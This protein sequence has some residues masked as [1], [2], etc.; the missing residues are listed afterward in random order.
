MKK[1]FENTY[2]NESLWQN[3]EQAARSINS[4]MKEAWLSD[5][6]IEFISYVVG[7]HFEAGSIRKRLDGLVALQKEGEKTLI[8]KKQDAL[9]PKYKQSDIKKTNLYTLEAFAFYPDAIKQIIYEEMERHRKRIK[10]NTIIY[11]GIEPKKILYLIART[12][13][14][15]NISKIKETPEFSHQNPQEVFAQKIAIQHAVNA[16]WTDQKQLNALYQGKY[17]HFVINSI[18]DYHFMQQRITTQKE[19]SFTF[20]EKHPE[21]LHP[22]HMRCY[23]RSIEY[24]Y[25]NYWISKHVF[26]YI[27]NL[28]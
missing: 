13:L 5:E 20:D 1:R 3:F 7:V 18:K 15:D 11:E 2:T 22:L 10:E 26:E 14:W 19:Q 28:P 25:I 21:F 6:Q 17:G 23:Q 24:M 16:A 12:F 9:S 27:H 4:A 8:T